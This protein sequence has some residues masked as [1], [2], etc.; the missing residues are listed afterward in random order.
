MLIWGCC[1]V[2]PVDSPTLLLHGSSVFRLDRGGPATRLTPDDNSTIK[3]MDYNFNNN[4][5]C[6]VS[7]ELNSHF[8]SISF[9]FGVQMNKELETVAGHRCCGG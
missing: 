9:S 4:S 1:T 7:I 6:Y 5:F 3:T 2:D 8:C